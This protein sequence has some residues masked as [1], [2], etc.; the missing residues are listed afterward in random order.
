MC[1]TLSGSIVPE[2]SD[3]ISVGGI[4]QLKP[5]LRLMTSY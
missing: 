5:A 4:V 3:L 2:L 1:S